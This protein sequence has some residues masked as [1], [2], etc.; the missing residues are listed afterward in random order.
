MS[1][2]V[3]IRAALVSTSRIVTVAPGT[4]APLESVT[5]PAIDPVIPCPNELCSNPGASVSNKMTKREEHQVDLFA[6]GVL[7]LVV[8]LGV[9]DKVFIISPFLLCSANCKTGNFSTFL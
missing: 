5:V 2:V 9:S 8:W 7:V 1:E 4:P 3:T 6:G